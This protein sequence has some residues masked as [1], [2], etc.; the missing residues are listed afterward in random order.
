MHSITRRPRWGGQ[1]R[2]WYVPFAQI[3]LIDTIGRLDSQFV[4]IFWAI[5]SAGE[6]TCLYVG[7]T[8]RARC[9]GA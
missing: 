2:V 5:D 6:K 7:K 9:V 1:V 3:I 8:F 4:Y